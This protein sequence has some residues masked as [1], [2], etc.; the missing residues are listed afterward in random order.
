MC[1]LVNLNYFSARASVYKHNLSV[2]I[3]MVMECVLCSGVSCQLILAA[4]CGWR[5]RG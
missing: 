4:L 1:S 5:G 3:I 2:D